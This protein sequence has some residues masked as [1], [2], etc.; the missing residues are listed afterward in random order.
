MVL[1]P[2]DA[3][4]RPAPNESAESDQSLNEQGGFVGLAVWCNRPHDVTGR[5]W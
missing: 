4:V 5:P 1:V 3:N 2:F